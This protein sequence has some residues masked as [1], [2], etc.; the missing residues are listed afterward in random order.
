[1]KRV[2]SLV[3]RFAKMDG[4]VLVSGES[5]TGKTPAAR[6]LHDLSPNRDG[7]FV[8]IHCAG[9]ASGKSGLAKAEAEEPA[10]WTPPPQ[11]PAG[12]RSRPWFF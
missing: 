2:R 8:R 11:A 12:Q 3:R 4:N 9:L 6:L 1:M 7:P 5:G 10:S